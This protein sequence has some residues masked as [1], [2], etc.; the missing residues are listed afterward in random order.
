MD[1]VN[2][3]QNKYNVKARHTNKLSRFQ[4]LLAAQMVY[5]EKFV[6]K[7]KCPPLQ[8]LGTEGTFGFVILS[9]LLVPMYWI[10]IG[11]S[12]HLGNS[13]NHVLEVQPFHLK[14]SCG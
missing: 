1:Y 4:A 14:Y 13:P 3:V 2:G 11:D 9:I 10:P 5:E 8:T 12:I 7:Y 6:K